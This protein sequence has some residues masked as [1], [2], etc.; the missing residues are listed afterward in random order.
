[1]PCIDSQITSINRATYIID[2][3]WLQPGLCK[4]YTDLKIVVTNRTIDRNSMAAENLD[5]HGVCKHYRGTC[6]LFNAS[7]YEYS[8]ID[9]DNICQDVHDKGINNGNMVWEMYSSSSGLSCFTVLL[10]FKTNGR[11]LIC[12]RKKESRQEKVSNQSGKTS[13]L[14]TYLHSTIRTT[15]KSYRSST[16]P[17]TMSS[18]YRLPTSDMISSGSSDVHRGQFD[19]SMKDLHHVRS[20]ND[21]DSTFDQFSFSDVKDYVQTQRQSKIKTFCDEQPLSMKYEVE[22]STDCTNI[23]DSMVHSIFSSAPKPRE[24]KWKIITLGLK[25]N[26]EETKVCP[27]YKVYSVHPEVWLPAG[28][29]IGKH[30]GRTSSISI[31]EV[32]SEYLRELEKFGKYKKIGRNCSDFAATFINLMSSKSGSGRKVSGVDVMCEACHRWIC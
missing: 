3:I 2:N 10:P 8:R 32:I 18:V 12:E 26:K 24:R 21:F 17:T 28:M 22:T 30:K 13:D 9:L 20:D 31:R 19:K 23:S 15:S 4:E 16:S 25:L 14:P 27:C 7:P 1:M 6:C 11:K 29:V 5:K